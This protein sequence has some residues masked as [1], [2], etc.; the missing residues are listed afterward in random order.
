M[1]KILVLYTSVGLGHKFIAENIAYHLEQAGY[2][3]HLHDILQV[4]EGVMVNFGIWLH[5]FINRRLPFIWRWLYFSHLVNSISIPLRIPLA[6]TNSE[7]LLK[8]VEQFK[9]DAILSTQTTASAAV[10]SLIEQKKFTGKFIIA[11]SD[12]HLH[13]FWL[14]DQADLYLANIDEQKQ[15]MVRLGIDANKIIVCGITLKPLEPI[16]KRVVKQNLGI[17][18]DDNNHKQKI[19]IFGSGSLGIGFDQNLLTDYLKQLVSKDENIHVLVLCG[20]NKQLKHY[21]DVLNIPRVRALDFYKNPSELY[22]VGDVLL[23][24]PGGLTIA[25]SLQAGIKIQITHTLPGQEEPN[26]DY[27]LQNN[28]VYPVPQPLTAKNLVASTIKLLNDDEPAGET[29]TS[30]FKI[31]QAGQEGKILKESI[32]KLFHNQ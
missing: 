19:V 12:Y 20:K 28:F 10:A 22:Q 6:K 9:P 8:I 31:T 21:L 23:T 1:K 24:K 4:Q 27:L 14:Y 11:F 18:D 13:K 3:I 7:N 15:E 16:A 32:N 29:S 25:E 5:S 30:S 17:L 26:Y 2:E